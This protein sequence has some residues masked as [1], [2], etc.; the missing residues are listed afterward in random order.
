MAK[1]SIV[2]GATSQTVDIFIQDSSKTTGAGLAGLVF[3]SSGLTWYYNFPR[4]ASTQVTLATLAAATSA[5]SSGG[6][7]E[8]DSTGQPGKYRIDVPNAAIASANG[9]YV[10]MMLQG[11]TNMAP[12][13]LEIEL[14]GWDN[15]DAVRGGLTALPNANAG[16]SNGLLISGTNSG[17]TTLGALT[18]TGSFTISDGL[19]ISRSSSNTS[20]VTATG[21][22]TGSGAVFTSGAGATGDGI[23]ATSNAT[24]GNGVSWAGKGTGQG[25]LSTGGA[26]GNGEKLVGGATSG[27]GLAITTTSGDGLSITPTAGHGITVTGQG[28]TKHGINATGSATTGAGMALIGGATSGDGLKIT[29]TSGHGMNIAATGT[30][31]H[32]ITSTGGNGG[33]SD[34]IKGV[35]GA[36]G[37]DIRGNITGNLVGTVSTLTTYTGN[38]VQTGDSYS[39][40]GAPAGASIA[41]DLAEIE[42]ETDGI[43][44]IPTSNP[45]AAAI[46]TAVWQ[47]ATAG[48]FT[49][50]SSIGKSLY[51][52]GI[53]PGAANGLFIA[54]TNAATAITTGLTAHIIGTVDTLT[55]YTGNTPQTGD[56]FARIGAPVGAS[57]SADIAEIEAETDALLAG[58]IVTTNNDK[59]GYGITSNRKKGSAATFEFTMQDSTTGAD[60]TGLTVTS[61]ISKDGGAFASTTNSVTE[62]ANGWYQI[63]LTATEMTANNIA[64][65]MTATGAINVDLSIQTQP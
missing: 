28:T 7:K 10:S 21:N 64:L 40:I 55:T 2:A 12:C 54:G 4:A 31:M 19:L 35:A 25:A 37:V 42:A 30:S 18:C 27:A 9:R 49:V 59:A 43:A 60:K 5:Y 47:D 1:L 44:A 63:V 50:T 61:I 3:N 26:T 48:D 13:L 14:T 17:T 65:Q 56:S 23:Q 11:A 22:G 51:T 29:T 6:F 52:S 8:I 24:N 32:G 16:A 41:A 39:R 36:G 53:I 38:T 34:G 15:Q 20:A 58:V 57:I 62:V 45:S 33:T 46:A